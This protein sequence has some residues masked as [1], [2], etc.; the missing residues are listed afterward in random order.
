MLG[1]FQTHSPPPS[2][3]QGMGG[4]LW[5]STASAWVPP[6]GALAGVGSERIG[7]HRMCSGGSVLARLSVNRKVAAPVGVS[8]STAAAALSGVQCQPLPLALQA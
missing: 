1:I 7:G 2:V 4:A 6:M 3:G 8:F 5:D